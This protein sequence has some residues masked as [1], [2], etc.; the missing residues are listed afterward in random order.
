MQT[1]NAMVALTGDRNNM[2]W[3]MGLSPAEIL[4]L[5]SLHG[6]DAV[7]QI[8]PTGEEKREPADEIARLKNLYPGHVERIQNIWR[9]FPGTAFPMRIDQ[10]GLNSALLRPAEAA[11]SYK[12]SAKSA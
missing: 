7:I 10:L 1:L 5:Q 8:E 9:D 6:A 2:I 12:V 11:A 3:K 4:L